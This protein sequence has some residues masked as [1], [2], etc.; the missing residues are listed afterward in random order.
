[1]C[2]PMF[3]TRLAESMLRLTLRRQ[4]TVFL[5]FRLQL[6]ITESFVHDSLYIRSTP[7]ISQGT[8]TRAWENALE[9]KLVKPS[10]D[11]SIARILCADVLTSNDTQYLLALLNLLPDNGRLSLCKDIWMRPLKS[12]PSGASVRFPRY[13]IHPSSLHLAMIPFRRHLTPRLIL[14]AIGAPIRLVPAIRR[15]KHS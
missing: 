10:T 1:M 6:G 9:Y 7:S 8:S 14:L 3:R 12:R 15:A 4:P 2:E 11:M 5:T 13:V